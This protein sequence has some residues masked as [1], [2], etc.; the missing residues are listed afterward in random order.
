MH[1]YCNR[2]VEVII[3]TEW[4][5]FGNDGVLDFI[6]T[7]FD[8]SIDTNSINSGKQLSVFTINANR[9]LVS[10]KMC[11]R[12]EKMI[13]G[14]YIGELVRVVLVKLAAQHIIFNS[15][16]IGKLF[17]TNSFTSKMISKIEL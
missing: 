1:K 7:E 3:N 11:S 17:E 4:A 14:M 10:N 5:A 13:S 16:S 6:R 9:C 2:L 15:C 12:F 8:R